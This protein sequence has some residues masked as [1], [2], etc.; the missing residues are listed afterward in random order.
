MP[1]FSNGLLTIKIAATEI[2][3]GCAKP[4]KASS[5]GIISH[6]TRKNS[7]ANATKSYRN[8]HHINS[9]SAIPR[10]IKTTI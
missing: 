10:V 7:A 2:T 5:A 1:E 8:L 6:T 4:V 3:A 9:T